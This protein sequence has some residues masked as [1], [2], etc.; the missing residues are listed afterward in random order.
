MLKKI[1]TLALVFILAFLAASPAYAGG[2]SKLPLLIGAESANIADENVDR[3][4]FMAGGQVSSTSRIEGDLLTAGGQLEIAGE[5]L[6]DLRVAG[7]DILIS[8]NV[9]RDV[10][11]AGGEVRIL[12]S[13]TIN[14]YV[15]IFA[16]QVSINGVINSPVQIYAGSVNIGPTAQI[17]NDVN[18]TA[19]EVSISDSALITGTRNVHITQSAQEEK[20]KKPTKSVFA[21]IYTGFKVV[22]FLGKLL[23]LLLLVRFLGKHIPTLI[24]PILTK[25]MATLGWGLIK[26]IVA[27]FAILL[28]AITV[29][30]IPLALIS[31]V[32][33]FLAIYLSSVITAMALGAWINHKGWIKNKNPYLLSTLG[34]VIVCIICMI[35]IIGL[36]AKL[37]ILLLGLGALMQAVKK[38]L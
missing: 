24:K 8:G 7:G 27:P 36:L 14:G 37:I 19:S 29:I 20:V 23:V 18:I 30:G 31:T 6:E 25:P 32:F 33:Y 2:P 10:T 35:P 34:L 38:L 3:D 13:S 26:L 9:G 5:I 1:L 12:N 17:H 28:L 11:I 16:G 22:S 15:L 4:V 21:G